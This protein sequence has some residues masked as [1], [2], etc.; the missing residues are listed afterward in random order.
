[1]K[2]RE[3]PSERALACLSPSRPTRRLGEIQGACGAPDRPHESLVLVLGSMKHF[4]V[5]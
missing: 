4:S 3:S 1:M 5:D 2:M